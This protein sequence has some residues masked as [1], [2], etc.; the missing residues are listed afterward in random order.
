MPFIN[1]Y[2][3]FPHYFIQSQIAKR[4][5]LQRQRFAKTKIH[6]NTKVMFHHHR[7]PTNTSPLLVGADNNKNNRHYVK[8]EVEEDVTDDSYDNS[9]SK[10]SEDA[11]TNV[12]KKRGESCFT[13]NPASATAHASATSTA[14]PASQHIKKEAVP[15]IPAALSTH[16]PNSPGHRLGR[17][18][19]F[20]PTD[21]YKPALA[22]RRIF[23]RNRH[24]SESNS[25][26]MHRDFL[27]QRMPDLNEKL[28]LL[29]FNGPTTPV[30]VTGMVLSRPPHQAQRYSIQKGNKSSSIAM[31]N[32]KACG[33]QW[34]KRIK[35]KSF[36]TLCRN[37]AYDVR[38]FRRAVHSRAALNLLQGHFDDVP[39]N[40]R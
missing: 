11:N 31:T 3:R 9:T 5:T 25:S 24:L 17:E 14:T 4:A 27:G 6:K 38:T 22:S 20:D 13:T 1:Y 12:K 21:V 10:H 16:T 8:L 7:T 37:V 18:L 35:F 23:N 36:L 30:G 33:K 28:A 26:S 15:Y 32:N 40:A 39:H 19:F 34:S 2:F 29:H